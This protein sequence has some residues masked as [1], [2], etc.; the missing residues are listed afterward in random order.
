MTR[1]HPSDFEADLAGQAE[2]LSR[3]ADQNFSDGVRDL[4]QRSFE[5]IILTDMGSSDTVTI[6]FELT[7]ARKGLPVWR[8][9]TSTLLE[10]PEM[11]TPR[12]LLWVTSQSGRSGEIVALLPTARGQNV[13]RVVAVTNDPDSPLGAAADQV[14]P[15]VS[16]PEATVSCKSYLNSLACFER[17]V[18]L[19]DNASD[20]ESVA[21]IRAAAS[22][23]DAG[24][25]ALRAVAH[26]IARRIMANPA[27]RVALIG[28]RA[29]AA[30]ALTGALI[31]K[32]AAK[33]PAEG[34]AGG[35]F[36][37]RSPRR[38]AR[39]DG[40]HRCRGRRASRR[41]YRARSG[42]GDLAIRT[43][44]R[45][46]ELHAAVERK[47]G[48]QHRHSSRRVPLRPED[49]DRCL[50][51]SWRVTHAALWHPLTRRPL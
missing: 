46:N 10:R 7:L 36:R 8:I 21:R 11:I 29:D 43:P 23:L 38:R 28:R 27:P 3:F 30:T 26:D 14:I 25:P 31:L 40:Q 47:P 16:G 5:R 6:P 34:Y 19:L 49:H 33:I 42:T 12:T 4:D 37:P 51:A 20:E 50:N 18:D 44:S 22:V 2:A 41:R 13:A 17:V 39:G 24:V 35:A 15:L 48:A 32:E 9:Q 1:S 45:R